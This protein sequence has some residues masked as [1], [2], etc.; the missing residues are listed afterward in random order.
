M[1]PRRDPRAFS[2]GAHFPLGKPGAYLLKWPENND[3][4]RFI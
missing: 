4:T 3:K 2:D 1:Q